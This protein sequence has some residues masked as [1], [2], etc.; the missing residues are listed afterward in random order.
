MLMG[1]YDGLMG[2]DGGLTVIYV[3][4]MGWNRENNGVYLGHLG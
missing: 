4:V 3:Y 1:I 2:F